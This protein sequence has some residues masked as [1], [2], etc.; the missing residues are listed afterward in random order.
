MREVNDSLLLTELADE[1]HELLAFS[2][3]ELKGAVVEEVLDAGR[4]L[5]RLLH[6][7]LDLD[8]ALQLGGQL[9][10]R[11]AIRGPPERRGR[12][13]GDAAWHRGAHGAEGRGLDDEGGAAGG[14][15]DGHATKRTR[16]G[17]SDGGEHGFCGVCCGA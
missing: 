10:V 6:I 11:L 13:G 16:R 9:I 1:L 15:C 3:D 2:V 17:C 5:L 4:L 14:G 7:L 8:L 12:E